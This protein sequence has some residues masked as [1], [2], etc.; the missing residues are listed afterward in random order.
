MASPV[1]TVLSTSLSAAHV[2]SKASVPSITL[3]AGLGIVGDCHAGET[4]QHRSR[5]HIQ[6]PPANLRQ[7]HLIPV[8]ILHS[9]AS[10]LSANQKTQL[11]APGA[12]GQNITT[13][14]IDLLA[15]SVGTELHFVDPA[16][17][18]GAVTGPVVVLAGL[19]NPC[20]QINKFQPGLQE[21]FLI[22]D[23]DRKI[24]GRLAGVMSTVK[25]GGA[26]RPGMAIRVVSPGEHVPL[27][28]V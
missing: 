10:T 24:V 14:G 9:V 2:F 26:I 4:V 8:E 18:E 12:L 22:R 23:A 7:V 21:R 20:P 15:L 17:E 1:P 16:M 11:L 13:Q 28:P 5:L 25:I 19:R 27:G 3:I 6:P